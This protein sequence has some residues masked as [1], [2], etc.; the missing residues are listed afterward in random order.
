M[1]LNVTRRLVGVIEYDIHTS[2]TKSGKPQR[3]ASV[4]HIIVDSYVTLKC[5]MLKL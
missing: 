1:Y 4:F 2:L 5:I 3:E